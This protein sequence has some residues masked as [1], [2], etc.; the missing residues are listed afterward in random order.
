MCTLR[1]RSPAPPYPKSWLRPCINW[2]AFD[3]APHAPQL[4]ADNYYVL[5]LKISGML[6]TAMLI[7]CIQV[8]AR[9][10]ACSVPTDTVSW[11]LCFVY[12]A[13]SIIRTS[14]NRHLNYPDSTDNFLKGQGSIITVMRMR[15]C[16]RTPPLYFT[17]GMH[18]A[19]ARS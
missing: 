17:T 14:V 8:S 18:E 15:I 3:H 10:P 6:V 5:M 4:L 16:K 9:P 2:G 11:F 19:C 12:S 7:S 1:A 13:T